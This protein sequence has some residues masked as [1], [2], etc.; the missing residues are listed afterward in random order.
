[1][2][3]FV[4]ALEGVDTRGAPVALAGQR[5]GSLA[6][7]DAATRASAERLRGQADVDALLAAWQL[8]VEAAPWTLAPRW[9]HG[10]LMDGNLLLQD[11]RLHG[12]IDWGGV[13]AADPA[14]ELMIAWNLFEPTARNAYR[15]APG[16]VDDATWLRG[17]A[18][19]TSAAVMAIPYYRDTNPDIV[20]RSW[21][22]I[23]HVVT[24]LRHG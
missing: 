4:V 14:V 18:W 16:F 22:C 10:D 12:V 6:A 19:A 9:V 15:V 11:G 17:R 20:R 24:D 5:G 21:R 3:G 2:A 8:G 7:A 1:V 13:K 23:E